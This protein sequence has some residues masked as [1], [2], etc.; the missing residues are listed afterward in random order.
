MNKKPPYIAIC[1]LLASAVLAGCGPVS[2][3]HATSTPRPTLAPSPTHTASPT[4][5]PTPTVTPT[6]L[7]FAPASEDQTLIVIASFYPSGGIPDTE[8]HDEIRRAIQEAKEELGIPDLRIEL[9]PTR[10]TADDR[11]GAEQLGKRYNADVVIWGADTGVR[12]TVNLLNLEQPHVDAA[13]FRISETERALLANPEAYGSFITEDLPGQ[14]AFLSLFAVG[15][16]HY[17]EGDWGRS[18]EAIQGAVGSL[19]PGTDPPEGLADAYFRL[20]WLRGVEPDGDE[21]AIQAIAYYDQAIALDPNHAKAY[22]NRGIARRTLGDF[23]GAI[24]D[25]DQ[26]IA[27]DPDYADAYYNR[28]NARRHQGDVEG[29]IADF[30]QVIA[31]EPDAADA[32]LNRGF[33][34]YE[35]GDLQEAIADFGAVIALDPAY[36]RAYWGRG[37]AH[38]EVGHAEAALADFRRYLEL[39]PDAE[40]REMFE[41]WIAELEAQLSGQ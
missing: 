32:Y 3:P 12:V 4:A 7:P 14:L 33:A 37:S 9:E 20:G 41:E 31:L 23:E 39:R 2:T 6:P 34:R 35:R 11:T 27:L 22:N 17:V 5:T 38:R 10:L 29:V 19:A 21:R 13:E 25:Y 40:N 8:A 26:A 24:G 16:T 15:Q 36:A 18:R 28:A 1:L 30:G